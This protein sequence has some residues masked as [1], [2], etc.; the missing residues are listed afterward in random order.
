[1]HRLPFIRTWLGLLAPLGLAGCFVSPGSVD[2][3][4]I[5][6]YQEAMARR[7]P[8]R[9]GADGLDS[10][11]PQRTAGVPDLKVVRD[12]KTG[13]RAVELTLDDAIVRALANST[14]IS[15]VSFEPAIA[16]EDVVQAAAAFDAVAFA[17]L[18]HEKT[19]ERT[20]SIFGG[21]QSDTRSIE[22][23]VSARTVTGATWT[24]KVT[25]SRLWDNIGVNFLRQR[26]EGEAAI[27]V[28]QPLLR[29]GWMDYN[30]ARL[31]VARLNHKATVAAFRE[32][33][34][35]I[36]FEVIRAYWMLHQARRDVVI[37]ESLLASTQETLRKLKAR[38]GV[39]VTQVH[40]KQA[41][42]AVATRSAQLIRARKIALDVRDHLARLL[43]APRVNVLSGV[44]I[45]PVTAP[46]VA[47]V[48]IDEAGQILTALK[49]N[50]LL[51]Q[52]R[53]AIAISD[54]A[55][56][57]ARNEALPRLDLT[58]SASLQGLGDTHPDPWEKILAGDYASYALGLIFEYPLGNRERRA[59]IRRARLERLRTIAQTQNIADNIAQ[60]VNERVR[61]IRTTFEE[62]RAQQAAVEAAKVQLKALDDTEAI[63]AQLTPEFLQLKL[64]AQETLAG[65]QRAEIQ[66]T[67]DYNT[68]AA[69]LAKVTGT[70]LQLPGVKVEL[71][72]DL[73]EQ[74]VSARP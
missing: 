24:G 3:D 50:P 39:D 53:H 59:A 42:A 63:R 66:A 21:G 28:T 11:R 31:R 67:V 62:L 46:A 25:A 22:A 72:T 35:R 34:E 41:E 64:Q 1:M 40:I 2:P 48:R 73:G 4:A 52:A 57:V 44:E 15:V 8:Q 5:L 26:Y 45:V 9:R 38:V 60:Q 12:D 69:E 71:P 56:K 16:R 43:S 6:R 58:A 29:Q 14:E 17:N 10:L 23:G 30:L 36:I 32:E 74:D 70:I 7:G 54:I 68:A 18:N 61:Q 37:Q 33:V 65:A 47:K 13:K 27:E 19:D 51:A 55:V 49:H 20:A